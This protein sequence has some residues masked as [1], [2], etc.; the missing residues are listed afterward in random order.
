M[1]LRQELS[2]KLL[3][4]V[5]PQLITAQSLLHCS[6]Q[7]LEQAILNEMEENPA[8]EWEEV[9]RELS[10]FAGFEA[11]TAPSAYPAD[12]DSEEAA[13]P[14]VQKVD[15]ERAFKNEL[16]FQ[17]HVHAPEELQ[18]VVERLIE[19]LD[20]SGYLPVSIEQLSSI[21][22][23]P[24]PELEAG[25]AFLQS[26]EPAG[27]GARSPQECLL[28]QV[29]RLRQDQE[30][31]L[32]EEMLSKAW[33]DFL[34][35]RKERIAEKLAISAE[36]VEE[37][38]QFIQKKL[39]LYPGN[40]VAPLLDTPQGLVPDVIIREEDGTFVPSIVEPRLR[41]VRIS[42]LYYDLFQKMKS[43]VVKFSEQEKLHIIHYLER[44]KNFLRA[45]E[46]RR[47]MLLNVARALIRLESRY[48]YTQDKKDMPILTQ[49]QLA[50]EVGVSES[51]VSR[52]VAHKN[53][54]LP[55][56]RVVPI[57]FFLSPCQVIKEK[58]LTV[59]LAEDVH[60]PLTDQKVSNIFKSVGLNIAR[61]TVAKYREELGIPST[62]VRR[63]MGESWKEP[64]S[65]K[66]KKS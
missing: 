46:G 33:D 31:Q 41:P 11:A 16:L 5:T 7:D 26:L 49:S 19:Q 50:Q 25:L 24:L 47:E 29:R 9:E 10:F 59:L 34:H 1:E 30:A 2:Q 64:F 55:W 21:W 63:R 44:T 61:R 45:L 43:N 3:L 14:F 56:G 65:Q 58:L 48:L 4:R 52:A 54:Q 51:T 40:G 15:D 12:H 32:V 39:T 42:P 62:S 66:R 17:A 13:M 18:A 6:N 36:K 53:I 27:V 38:F 22:K 60:R 8:L 20:S 35:L 57:S 23:L 37:L 28:L